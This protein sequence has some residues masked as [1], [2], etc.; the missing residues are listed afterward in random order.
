MIF[1]Y[2]DF[3]VLALLFDLMLVVK[4][5]QKIGVFD[6]LVALLFKYIADSRSLCR[7]LVF[8]SFFLSMLI[9]NDVALITMVPFTILALSI[10]GL[11]KEVIPVVVLQTCAANLGSMFTPIGNP[12]NLY[13]FSLAG[14]DT[15]TF[16][17]WM[18]PLTA[19]S[20]ILLFLATFLV[21]NKECK[22]PEFNFK[23][24]V[25]LKKLSVFLGLG[26]LNILVVLHVLSWELAFVITVCV[27]FIA[28]EKE[29][30]G[31]VDYKLLLTFT[32]VFIIVGLVGEIETVSRFLRNILS[33]REIVVSALSS[34][35][36][37]NVP[38]AVLLSGFTDN[39]KG[40]VYG[41]NIG[42]LGTLIASMASLISY[43]L[44]LEKYKNKKAYL[45]TFTLYNIIGFVILLAV[46]LIIA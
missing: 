34:Q 36:I 24:N 21:K 8:A 44:Y 16:L 18:L 39:I 29:L 7:T 12:Q 17:G 20:A 26:V 35:F 22:K 15:L 10:S 1:S 37:S 30:F 40:I 33:G 6:R 27:T 23:E 38:A 2:I 32:I 42:G 5:L 19:V 46:G 4:G 31:K 41:T 14:V 45:Y 13:L 43:R 28:G 9:T 3:R 25:N 11:E